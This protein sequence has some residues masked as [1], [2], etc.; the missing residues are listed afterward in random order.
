MRTTITSYLNIAIQTLLIAVIAITPLLFSSLTTEFI[1]IPKII[2]LVIVTFILLVLWTFSWVVEGRVLITRTPF[3]IPLLLFLA[4]VV[5]S[6]LLSANPNYVSIWGNFPKVHGSLVSWVLYILLYFIAVSNIKTQ[7]QIRNII[8]AYIVSTTLLSVL[9]LL[10]YFNIYVLPFDYA[11]T[12][13]FNPAGSSFASSALMVLA[14][15]LF[16]L[17]VIKPGKL[18]AVNLSLGLLTLYLVTIALTGN[19]STYVATIVALIIP[20]LIYTKAAAKKSLG[21]LIIP[22]VIA[23][24][25]AGLN[26]LSNIKPNPLAKFKNNYPQE[27]L[28]S[29]AAS[30]EVSGKS[31]V[32]NPFVGSGPAT[33]LFNFNAFKPLALNYSK[34]WTAKFDTGF[35]EYLTVL[36]TLGGLGFVS[37]LFLSVIIL[38]FSWKSIKN[39]EYQSAEV[40]NNLPAAL[41]LSSILALV[42]LALHPTTV[43]TTVITLMILALLAASHKSTSKIEEISLGIKASRIKD[44]NVIIGDMLPIIV[45]SIVLLLVIAGAWK[46]RKVVLADYYHRLALKAA[47]STK[48]L[49]YDCLNNNLKT[50]Q[51]NGIVAYNCLVKTEALNPQIDLYRT[52]LAQTNF[53]IANAIALSKGPTEASPSGSLTDDDKKTIQQLLSQSINEARTATTLSPRNAQNWEILA[54]IYRQISGVAENAT[55]F[56]LDSYGRSIALDPFNPTLRLNA[57][58]V[59]YSLK[60]YDLAIRFFSDS[61]QLKP[62]FANGY[63]NLSVALRDKGD[64]QNAQ[65]AAETVLSLLD[66]KSPD[67]KT[68]SEYLT[69][70]KTRIATGSAQESQ[71]KAPAAEE[72]SALQKKG[73]APKVSLDELKQSPD[74]IATPPAVKK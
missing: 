35:N 60:N 72:K 69:D 1:E 68:A 26:N 58:G 63:Y 41:A 67:Y 52:D 13:L 27:I 3:D 19:L 64:L 15:P 6:T 70:L 71:I 5:I 40:H 34:L 56:A 21:L 30:W 62:D 61:V 36:G 20:F 31:F 38:G 8:Y 51:S 29:P 23:L 18:L 47:A 45:F 48:P 53:A 50:P 4:I 65:K 17:P 73:T 10:Y 22:V 46:T 37:L 39:N 14:L 12:T 42:L 66:P 54:S 9:T 25:L 57:G 2:F 55:S 49:N 28:L 24:I 16:I 59:Y 32:Q 44:Q 43:V 74:K 11:K 33:Y 7:S